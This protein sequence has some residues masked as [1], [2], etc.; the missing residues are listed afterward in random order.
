M[1]GS[2]W[3]LVRL[4]PL[5][6]GVAAARGPSAW[7]ASGG[8]GSAARPPGA[9]AEPSPPPEP[10]HEQTPEQC[11]GYYD[12]MGQFDPPFVCQ[13]HP[14]FICCGSCGFRYCCKEPSA[15]LNQTQC[16]KN[17]TPRLAN[18]STGPPD[19][20]GPFGPTRDKT[21]MVVYSV[22]GIVA[23]ML[24][25][26]IFTKV[27]LYK[28]AGGLL[29]A[30]PPGEPGGHCRLLDVSAHQESGLALPTDSGSTPGFPS[31]LPPRA[32]SMEAG[33]M[34][35][36][37]PSLDQPQLKTIF[38]SQP[39]L[40][41]E[42][43]PTYEAANQAEGGRHPS[44]PK[45][46]EKS[47]LL[48]HFGK[49]HFS[50]DAG[51]PTSLPLRSA[52]P[53]KA[54]TSRQASEASGK[55]GGR[56]DEDELAGA[57]SRMTKMHSHP[58]AW[59]SPARERS[60]PRGEGDSVSRSG[61]QALH[62]QQQHHHHHPHHHHHH[63]PPHQQSQHQSQHEHHQPQHHQLQHQHQ[64]QH[65]HHTLQHHHTREQQQQQ[66]PGGPG[67][68]GQLSQQDTWPGPPRYHSTLDRVPTSGSGS[69]RHHQRQQSTLR[70]SQTTL[71]K[72]EVTV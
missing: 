39:H 10:S 49:I 63:Q 24:L 8:A 71:S 7:A 13:K 27:G 47:G 60:L 31:M 65:H 25:A 59:M 18:D 30:Q 26:G 62:Q 33:F 15:R 36:A 14:F 9:T 35:G 2:R 50:S 42:A 22:C 51:P 29:P 56:G 52:T 58:G 66:G 4:V 40:A 61:S 21:H 46:I 72:A 64:Q 20:V 23:F 34:H 68:R 32:S 45:R 5:L 57:K 67:V 17:E 41:S 69:G 70:P 37:R 54:S 19:V 11:R 16:V 48:D 44:L 38:H 6:L 12:V 55:E 1:R 53:V 28:P 3:L 43:P